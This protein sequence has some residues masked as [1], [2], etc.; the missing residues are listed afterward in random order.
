MKSLALIGTPSDHTALGLIWYTTVCGFVLVSLALVT[1]VVLSAGLRFGW[2]VNTRGS[3]GSRISV[4]TNSLSPSSS[5][6]KPVTSSSHAEGRVPPLLTVPVFGCEEPVLEAQ[7]ATASAAAVRNK[8][9]RYQRRW[10]VGP[11]VRRLIGARTAS[12]G[13]TGTSAGQG[14]PQNGLFNSKSASDDGNCPVNPPGP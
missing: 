2:T 9:V 6:L 13:L 12:V 8:R 3:V 14:P 1:N 4:R 7:P 11:D 5:V 10:P